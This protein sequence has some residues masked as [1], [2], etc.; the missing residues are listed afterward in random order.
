[1]TP[2]ATAAVV[3]RGDRLVDLLPPPRQQLR[4]LT[5]AS[6]LD[7][8]HLYAY[9][10]ERD[11]AVAACLSMVPLVVATVVLWP[12]VFIAAVLVLVAVSPFVAISA[13]LRAIFR[14]TQHRAMEYET[15]S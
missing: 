5:Q 11:R 4:L 10:E 3:Q 15:D 1:M 6:L 14:L 7:P 12:I 9:Q 8:L 2:I 13:G